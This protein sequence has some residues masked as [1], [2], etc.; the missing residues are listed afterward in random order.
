MFQALTELLEDSK[1]E[2]KLEGKQEGED[3][4]GRLTLK[5]LKEKRYKELELASKDS[6]A[7]NRLYR[8]FK[9]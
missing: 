8:E 9:L 5:L 3:R 1:N 6:R 7:R 2:V 4:F